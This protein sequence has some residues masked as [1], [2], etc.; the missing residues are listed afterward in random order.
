MKKGRLTGCFGV[1]TGLAAPAC[2]KLISLL[3]AVRSLPSDGD[4]LFAWGGGVRVRTGLLA[5]CNSP[6]SSATVLTLPA[7][8][9]SKHMKN[10]YQFLHLNLK[11]SLC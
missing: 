6:S 9:V 4:P 7:A 5:C 10:V 8:S 3:N 11:G 1:S 2:I